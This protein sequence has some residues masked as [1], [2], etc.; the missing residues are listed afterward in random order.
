MAF[1]A[2]LVFLVVAIAAMAMVVQSKEY[3]HIGVVAE[4]DGHGL[5][6]DALDI[7]EELMMES[8]SARRQLARGGGY[9]SYGALNRNN[10]PCNRRGRSYYNCGGHQK[11]NPYTR[12]CTR[13]SRCAR[14][15][16]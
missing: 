14:N 1:R 11:A 2:G 9:I 7:D 5:V 13:A 8:E 16:R 6:A 3:M 12:G 15:N 10:V 4:P